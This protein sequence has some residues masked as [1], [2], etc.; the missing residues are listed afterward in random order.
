MRWA[1]LVLILFALAFAG[2]QS[3]SAIQ[4]AHTELE[5]T[6][7]RGVANTRH[8]RQTWTVEVGPDGSRT[9]RITDVDPR[10]PAGLNGHCPPGRRCPV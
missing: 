1:I 4:P 9:F 2:C 8:V 3:T 5:R 6:D 10:D 7:N